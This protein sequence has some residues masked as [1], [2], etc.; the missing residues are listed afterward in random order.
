VPKVS[1]INYQGGKPGKEQWLL[2]Y[3]KLIARPSVEK[4]S[5]Y[6]ITSDCN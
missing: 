6:D 1:S 4:G 2:R 5:I 3:P